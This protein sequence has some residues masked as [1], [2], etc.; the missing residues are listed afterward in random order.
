MPLPFAAIAAGASAAQSLF[1]VGMGI[2]QLIRGGKRVKRP[3]YEIPESLKKVVAKTGFEASRTG[4]AGQDYLFNKLEQSSAGMGRSIKDSGLSSA[5]IIAGL[6]SLDANTKESVAGIG[7]NAEEIRRQNQG[8][9]YQALGT[10]AEEEKNKWMWEKRDAY[11]ADAAQTSADMGAGL[12]NIF[13][14]LGNIS[15]TAGKAGVLDDQGAFQGQGS[16]WERFK[17]SVD[18]QSV[19]T[20][21]QQQYP[22]MIWDENT[23]KAFLGY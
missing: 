7:Y 2:S 14:G 1:G 4:M 16:E 21:L 11:L 15:T 3:D 19:I 23:V 13:Q 17:S 10:M 22:G 5:S 18:M 6:A 20:D 12:Q 8:L 9:Y